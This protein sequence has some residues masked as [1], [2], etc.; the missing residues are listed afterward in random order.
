MRNSVIHGF[1][2]PNLGS[3]IIL[4][5]IE[6]VRKILKSYRRKLMRCK[7]PVCGKSTTTVGTL[8]SHLVNI[9][10]TRHAR[11]LESYCQTNNVNFGRLLVD[12]VKGIKDANKPLTDVLKR[13]F[14]ED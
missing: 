8:F 2:E 12:R 6:T 4:N 11:W 1:I 5:V 7:C 14:C 13:D 10:D 9:H 3:D